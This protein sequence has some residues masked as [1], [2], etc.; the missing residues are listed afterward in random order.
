[1]FYAYEPQHFRGQNINILK[2]DNEDIN[3][4]SDVDKQAYID[5]SANF[6]VIAWKPKLKPEDAWAVPYVTGHKYRITWANDLDFT[7]MKV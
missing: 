1:V 6:S 5:E 4:L 2:F 7:L 3:A